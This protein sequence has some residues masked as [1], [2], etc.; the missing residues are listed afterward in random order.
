MISAPL[1]MGVAGAGYFGRFHAQKVAANPRATLVG[2]TDRDPARAAVLAQE[3]GAP[4]L[5]WPALLEAC[6]AVVIA[7]P[8][9][10]H[11]ALAEAALAA[12]RHVLVEKPITETLDQ[13]DRLAARAAAG[14]LV[15]QVGHLLRYTAEHRAISARMPN[16]A[17]IECLRIAPFKPRGTDVSVVLDL[18]IHDLDFVLSLVDSELETVEAMGAPVASPLDDIANAR[19]SFRNGCVASITASRISMRTERKMRLFGQQGYM[20]VDFAARRLSMLGRDA[21][22]PVPGIPDARIEE[23]SWTDHDAL[24]AEHQAFVASVLDA[25]PVLVDAAAG[26]RALSA[27]LDVMQ[28]MAAS[29]AKAEA[30][31]L[32]RA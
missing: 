10:S 32:I 28:A 22:L 9:E 27:A 13:A 8:A 30:S 21:G 29:R 26:R 31:G 19:L 16:P 23:V 14:G 3:V 6:D 1:R 2:I 15:L 17:Y 7:S 18:M 25:A 4:A 11:F 20:T 5:E 24:A 12:G